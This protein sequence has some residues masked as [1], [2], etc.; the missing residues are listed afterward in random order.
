M[1]KYRK[2]LRLKSLGFGEQNIAHSYGVCRNT[3]AK[4]VKKAVEIKLSRSLDHDM[5]DS[6]LD[7][8]LFSKAKSATNKRMPDYDYIRRELL[9]NGVNKNL[10]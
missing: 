2:I 3:V 1:T 9:R 8:M 7:K 5:T 6:T 10:L 4:V